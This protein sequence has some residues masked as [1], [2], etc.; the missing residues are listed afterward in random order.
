[1][2]D[3]VRLE[4]KKANME[5]IEMRNGNILMHTERPSACETQTQNVHSLDRRGV[6]QSVGTKLGKGEKN[7]AINNLHNNMMG[8]NELPVYLLRILFFLFYNL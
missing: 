7:D 2:L 4:P 3:R 5:K 6:V 8:I 1:M